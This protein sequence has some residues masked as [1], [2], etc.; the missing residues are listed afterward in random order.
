MVGPS[1]K[2]RPFTPGVHF[3]EVAVGK[4]LLSYDSLCVYTHFK[5]HTSGGFGGSLKN[6]AIGCASEQ[7]GKRQTHGEGWP[8]GPLF[9]ERMVEAG[10]GISAHFGPHITYINVLKNIS[11]E[12]PARRKTRSASAPAK[13]SSPAM[14]TRCRSKPAAS[15]SS[16]TPSPPITTST[17]ISTC[18]AATA[19]SPYT[20]QA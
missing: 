17:P 1:L 11:M 6:I 8:K 9:L 7:V 4:N 15:T 14:P 13:S 19:T 20:I 10:K 16:S 2:Q 18:S 3:T 5:G 12:R